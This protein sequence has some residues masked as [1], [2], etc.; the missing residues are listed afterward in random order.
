VFPPLIRRIGAQIKSGPF[1]LVLSN[2]SGLINFG[3]DGRG[4]ESASRSVRWLIAASA[5][6]EPAT[7]P[8][9]WPTI[10]IGIG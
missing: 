4:W 9:F 5:C 8:Y 7:D 1:E 2:G 6:G 3:Y 10:W